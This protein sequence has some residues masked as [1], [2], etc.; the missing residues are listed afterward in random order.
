[1]NIF[2]CILD[3]LL[4]SLQFQEIALAQEVIIPEH[5]ISVHQYK[6]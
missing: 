2:L 1:L 4:R 6:L 3:F 5:C